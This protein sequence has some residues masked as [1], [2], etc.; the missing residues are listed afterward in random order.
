MLDIPVAEDDNLL[1]EQWRAVLLTPETRREWD[2]TVESNELLEMFDSETRIVKTKF[3]A[4][5]PAK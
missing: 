4:G 3:V 5:W 2:T 1:V